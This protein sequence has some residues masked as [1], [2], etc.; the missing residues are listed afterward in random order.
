MVQLFPFLLLSSPT[1]KVNEFCLEPFIRSLYNVVIYHSCYFKINTKVNFC[2]PS[3]QARTLA[4]PVSTANSPL[5][6]PKLL[7][8]GVPVLP[9]CSEILKIS[10]YCLHILCQFSFPSLTVA[11]ECH[12]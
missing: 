3:E 11:L 7:L 9:V 10:C 4:C 8:S 5:Q 6:P 12:L 1:V 2:S